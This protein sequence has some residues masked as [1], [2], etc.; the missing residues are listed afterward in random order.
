MADFDLGSDILIRHKL[1]GTGQFTGVRLGY[2]VQTYN[3]GGASITV[4]YSRTGVEGNSQKVAYINP[5]ARDVAKCVAKYD[6]G[7]STLSVLL[8]K[9]AGSITATVAETVAAIEDSTD[10]NVRKFRAAVVTEA[11]MGAQVATSLAGGLDPTGTGGRFD[12]TPA[13]NTAGGLFYFDHNEP[14]VL[15]AVRG[16]FADAIVG[17]LVVSVRVVEVD[18]ALNVTSAATEGVRIHTESIAASEYHLS[19]RTLHEPV[20]P[21]QAVQVIAAGTGVVGVVARRARKTW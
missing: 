17:P 9:A 11:T 13:T 15:E 16:R 4:R 5:G 21:G 18:A 14:W 10:P 12:I 20:F 6:A 1:S 8:K 2:A 3:S 7:T 19:L